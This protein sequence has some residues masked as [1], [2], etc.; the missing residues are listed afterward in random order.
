[1]RTYKAN[2]PKGVK[3]KFGT[4]RGVKVKL[5]NKDLDKKKKNS[6]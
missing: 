6:K 3:K 2:L 5:I 1:M 4:V